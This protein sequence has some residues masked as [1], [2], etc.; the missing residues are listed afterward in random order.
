MARA[1]CEIALDS[2][3]CDWQVWFGFGMG[4]MQGAEE[5][6]RG[7]TGTQAAEPART[8][9]PIAAFLILLVIGAVALGALLL[10]REDEAE[11]PSAHDRGPAFALTDEEAIE[12]FR[13]LEAL[14]IRAYRQRNLSL[15][16]KVYV[17]GG[18]G[19]QIVA[20]EIRKLIR[21]DVLDRSTFRTERIELIQNDESQ[22]I[23]RQTEVQ[24]S[25][26]VHE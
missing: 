24:S 20:E 6:A 1:I 21:A 17:P 18:E 12:R 5:P 9:S 19:E 13:E 2:F 11:D 25:R 15:I 3:S 8:L 10:T 23:V 22:I 16:S 4:R 7:G 14:Q 26:F